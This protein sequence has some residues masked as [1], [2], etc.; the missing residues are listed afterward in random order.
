ML[1]LQ[2]FPAPKVLWRETKIVNLA[3][4]WPLHKWGRGSGSGGYKQMG[5]RGHLHVD[6]HTEN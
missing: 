2:L 6:V 5:N 1:L 3:K 4:W